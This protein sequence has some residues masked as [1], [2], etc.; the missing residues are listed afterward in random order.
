MRRQSI[1]QLNGIAKVTPAQGEGLSKRARMRRWAEL[2]DRLGQQ[3][4]TPLSSV[5]YY[6][7]RERSQLRGDY[8]PIALAYADPVLRGEGLSGD[9]FG[10]AQT[11]FG[12]NGADAHYLL[13]DCHYQGRMDGRTVAKRLRAM[14]DPNPLYRMWRR[15]TACP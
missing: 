6:A 13:C 11:F 12:L 8:T 2:L 4:L 7:E 1:E 10:D 15:L 14:A 3:S 9:T 5:E